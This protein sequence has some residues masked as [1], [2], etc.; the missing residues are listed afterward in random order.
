MTYEAWLLDLDGTLYHPLGVKL[1]MGAELVL[2]GTPSIA[3]IRTFRREHERLR[4]EGQ[5]F[6]DG[7]PFDE[8]VRGAAARCKV[9]DEVV[10][11]TVSR[12]MVERPAKWV[13]VFR[14]RG[15][16]SEI[17]SYRAGG[18][19]TA[20]VSDY[21]ATAKLRS[22][23]IDSWFDTVVANGEPGGPPALKPQPHGYLLAAER[24]GVAPER[25]LVIGDRDDA[26]GL[27]ARRAGMSFRRIR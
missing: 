18:G 20:V 1:A 3:L 22:L 26:D 12:W 19:K 17:Q 23:G 7:S 10:R 13:S 4:I 14:R 27:A 24:L 2:F 11:S 25:C 5:V 21:P 16:L 6:E 9:D 8:Q 15:L